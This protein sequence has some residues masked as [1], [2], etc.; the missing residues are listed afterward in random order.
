MIR[1]NLG[2]LAAMVLRW[3]GTLR[4][5]L[6]ELVETIQTTWAALCLLYHGW[7][8]TR[9]WKA[10]RRNLNRLQR[11][12]LRVKEGRILGRPVEVL[13]GEDSEPE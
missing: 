8:V 4:H 9:N 7:R 13:T 11:A 2:K 6:M 12:T 10:H 1:K 3:A 5:V